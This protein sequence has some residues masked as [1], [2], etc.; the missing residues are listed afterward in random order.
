MYTSIHDLPFVCQLNLPEAA[1][2]VYRESF[3][4]AW[5]GAAGSA[6]R[7]ATAQNHAWRAVRE[8]FERDRVTGHWAAKS[9]AGLPRSRARARAAIPKGVS[10]VD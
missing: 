8:H 4:H 10:A 5:E 2:H 6:E 7:F 9:A 1:L 3:N